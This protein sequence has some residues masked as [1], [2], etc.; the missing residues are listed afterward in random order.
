MA[1]YKPHY[2]KNGVIALVVLAA[3]YALTIA[4]SRYLSTG[5]GL[6][7]QWYLRYG[8]GVVLGVIVFHRQISWRKFLH[9]PRRE[10]AVLLA[11]VLVGHVIAIGIYTL[12]VKRTSVGLMSFIEVLPMS[13]VVGMML[14]REKPTWRQTAALALSCVGAAVVTVGNAHDLLSINFGAILALI[15]MVF[16]AFSMV[17]RRWHSDVLN[18]QE[19][20]IAITGMGAIFQYILSVALY[21]RWMIP[22]SH[23]HAT[24]ALVLLAAGALNVVMYF[25][26]NYGFQHVNALFAGNILSLEEFFGPLFG[27]LFYGELLNAR[28]VVGGLIILLSVILMNKFARREHKA[29]QVPV[30]PD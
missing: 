14:F 15:A 17:T 13:S 12:A 9:L 29:V 28:D 19:L 27:F 2:T 30:V 3:I 16:Y 26:S 25:C 6:Y 20:T 8:I 23:W 21:H 5:L 22:A 4:V 10:W 1:A 7:E 24:F 11:R 18:N